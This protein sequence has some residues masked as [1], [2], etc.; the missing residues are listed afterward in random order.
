[1]E[2]YNNCVSV[3]ELSSLSGI[4][5]KRALDIITYRE[6]NGRFQTIEEIKNVTGIKDA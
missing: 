4:G 5:E 1:M 2:K 3:T 6:Q